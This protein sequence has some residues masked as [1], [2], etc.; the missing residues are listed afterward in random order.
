M[1]RQAFTPDE[2]VQIAQMKAVAVNG[3]DA[4][5]DAE[6]TTKWL[7]IRDETKW[8]YARV[9]GMM[10]EANMGT[11]QHPGFGYAD[12]TGLRATSAAAAVVAVAAA[13]A[14]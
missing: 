7:R 6:T 8:I 11:P 9:W 14:A 12:L 2:C 4:E 13:G 5:D 3:D 1:V 10:K